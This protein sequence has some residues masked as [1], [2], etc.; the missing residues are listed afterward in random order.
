MLIVLVVSQEELSN[1]T[2][3]HTSVEIVVAAI[4]YIVALV[5]ALLR[6]LAVRYRIP[7][8]LIA[9]VSECQGKVLLA[10]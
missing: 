10:S 5:V 3:Q 9:Q 1:I 4:F 6:H 2:T 7:M 8:L